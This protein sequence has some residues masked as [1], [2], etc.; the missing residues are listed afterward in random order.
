M[1][2]RGRRNEQVTVDI[3]LP[4]PHPGQQ[5]AYSKGAKRLALRCGRRWGKTDFLKLRADEAVIAGQRVGWFTPDHKRASEAFSE[6]TSAL[7]PITLRS[8]RGKGLY[9]ATNGGGIDFW[10]L[11]K[12]GAGRSRKYHLVVLDEAAFT[13]PNMMDEWERSIAP[14]LW[15]FDGDAI[16]A[17][18]PSGI[19]DSNFFWQLCNNPKHGFVEYHAKTSENPHMPP[20]LMERERARNT[21][22][23][24]Q[25]EFEAEFVDWTGVQF[26][27][28]QKL[29][30]HGQPVPMPAHV[31]A[32]F[33]T[34]DTAVKTGREHDGTAVIYWARSKYSGHPLTILDWDLVQIQGDLLE[35][36]LPT[37]F[38]NLKHL[39]KRCGARF[40]VLG[41][42]IEDK[43]SG[44]ILLQQ[45]IR[46]D[47]PAMAIDSKLTAVGKDER[48]VSVSGY[49]YQGQVKIATEPY[50]KVKDYKGN[51]YN[52]LLRQVFTFRI[53]DKDASREDDLLDCFCYGVAIDLGNEEGY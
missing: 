19:D 40:G 25:Q 18:T 29:L 6:I 34:I 51:T 21:P 8:D 31:D 46:R 16:A 35:T 17:S 11:E 48:A 27:D 36:W 22:L 44:T 45:A 20:D 2:A 53:G 1:S 26:F 23:V 52:H 13:R 33:A 10:S 42:H 37:V 32:V 38:Q 4:E 24:F 30:V 43:A 41:A 15:D 39:A 7:R 12:D 5:A 3:A 28:L 49:I 9:R 47:W 50:D 14:T